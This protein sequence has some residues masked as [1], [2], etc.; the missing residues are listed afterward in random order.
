AALAHPADS[1]GGHA[2]HQGIRRYVRGHHGTRADEGVLTERHTT[3]DCRVRANGRAALHPR[4]AVLVLAG[5]VAAWVH[6]VGK[7]ARRPTEYV[8]FERHALVD[9]DVVLNLD[10][11]PDPH[12]GHH[13]HVLAQV[14]ALTDRGTGHDVGEVPDLRTPADLRTVVEI[15]RFVDEELCHLDPDH[16]DL[17]LQLDAGLLGDRFPCVLDDLEHVTRRRSA[18]VDNVVRVQRGHL[19]AADGKALQ[20]A[21]V[22]Q[23]AGGA[24]TAR[25]L[26]DRAGARLV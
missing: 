19:R 14:A 12:A 9:R 4:L 10:V 13:H 26:E 15:A 24:R 20:P 16:L 1:T 21:F 23:G 2:H 18:G 5:H 6:D 17:E 25:I 11:V 8:V 7:H 3:D 22:D